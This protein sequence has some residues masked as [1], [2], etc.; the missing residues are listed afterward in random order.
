MGLI[1][2]MRTRP[3]QAAAKEE[4]ARVKLDMSRREPWKKQ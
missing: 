1:A 2:D 3:A 4:Q